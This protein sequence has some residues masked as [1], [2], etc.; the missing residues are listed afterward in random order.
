VKDP[1]A[2][3]V[4]PA[5]PHPVIEK[6]LDGVSARVQLAA[7]EAKPLPVTETTVPLVPVVGETKICGITV[8]LADAGISLAGVPFTETTHAMSDVA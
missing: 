7:V 6:P 2:W 5:T 1:E 4:V 3:P 8:K